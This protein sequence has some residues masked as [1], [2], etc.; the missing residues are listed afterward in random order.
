MAACNAC[1]KSQPRREYDDNAW[2]NAEKHWRNLVCTACYA[3]GF[4][5]KD[6]SEYRCKNGCSRGHKNF[7]PV[8]LDNHKRRGDKLTCIRCAEAEAEEGKKNAERE[9]DIKSRLRRGWKCTCK[10]LVHSEKCV[11]FPHHAGERRWP[12]KNKGVTEDD[13]EFLAKRQRRT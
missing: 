1:G 2:S 12:G 9:K 11:L 10:Q 13:L 6:I 3:L 4:T 5:P 8:N 7:K